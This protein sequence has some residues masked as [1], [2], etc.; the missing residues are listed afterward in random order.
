MEQLKKNAAVFSGWMS[1]ILNR[2]LS[3]KVKNYLELNG[4]SITSRAEEAEIIVFTGCAVTEP[5]ELYNLK[6][7]AYLEKIT[8]ELNADQKIVLIGCLQKINNKTRGTHHDAENKKR[9]IFLGNKYKPDPLSQHIFVDTYD[10][11]VFDELLNAKIK[12]EQVP[13]PNEIS[14]ISGIESFQLSHRAFKDISLDIKTDYQKNGLIH[15]QLQSQIQQHGF[16]YPTYSDNLVSY[17]YKNV[18]VGMGCK[19]NCAYCAIKFAKPKVKS[20]PIKQIIEQ[21]K[22]LQNSNEHKYILLCDDLRSWG[23]DLKQSWIDLLKAIEKV[24]VPATKIALFNVKVEDLLEEK[25]AFDQWVDAGLISYIGVMGQHVNKE[26][27]RLMKRTPFEEEDFINV[28][29]EYGNKGV[30]MHSYNIVGFPG[31]TEEQFYQLLSSFA[32]IKTENCSILNFHY[33]N[34][35]GTLAASYPDHV[36][37][38]VIRRR[39]EL[40]NKEYILTS[41]ERFSNLPEDIQKVLNE[42]ITYTAQTEELVENF[43]EYLCEML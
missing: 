31:E 11:S 24:S 33:S 23:L 12:F 25:M 9:E 28:I 7:L 29:N 36:S 5:V 18:Y 35:I 43:N 42:L 26:I 14:S 27:L 2:N 30:H 13:E 22:N 8:E 39:L 20:S 17:G 1:C 38:E 34:R 15:S 19:N 41:K 21:I 4:Y 32:K 3:Q 16:F 37:K 10:Y 40:L 6:E